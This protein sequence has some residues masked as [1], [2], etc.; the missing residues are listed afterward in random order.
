M[1]HDICQC[2]LNSREGRYSNAPCMLYTHHIIPCSAFRLREVDSKGQVCHSC[3]RN[4]NKKTPSKQKPSI[5]T[6]SLERELT[7]STKKFI[8]YC[9]VSRI[10][11]RHENV[12][13]V[14]LTISRPFIPTNDGSFMGTTSNNEDDDGDD[15]I[16][17]PPVRASRVNKSSG[18]VGIVDENRTSSASPSFA[19]EAA[20]SGAERARARV[21]GGGAY[22]RIYALANA[23]VSYNRSSPFDHFVN[24]TPPDHREDTIADLR[25]HHRYSR[26]SVFGVRPTV[27]NNLHRTSANRPSMSIP[28]LAS[29]FPSTTYDSTTNVRIVAVGM[30]R[31]TSRIIAVVARTVIF[32][33]CW[34]CVRERVTRV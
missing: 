34:T 23:A 32:V 17:P 24:E 5:Q 12:P 3:V 1:A 21:R 8:L 7:K 11:I 2:E 15:G 14:T 4:H 27:I 16:V 22:S 33:F 31:S 26:I 18:E 9:R 30:R 28:P 29:L 10:C 13:G 6:L 25:P 20:H 19:P